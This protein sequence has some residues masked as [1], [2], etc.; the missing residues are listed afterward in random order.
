MGVAVWA[1]SRT[2]PL[3]VC[4]DARLTDA[5]ALQYPA[6]THKGQAGW[7]VGVLYQD[8]SD[9]G[10]RLATVMNE[11]GRISRL[12][13]NSHGAPGYF[14]LDGSNPQLMTQNDLFLNIKTMGNRFNSQLALIKSYLTSDAIVLFMGCNFGRGE[15]G[16][17]FLRNLSGTLFNN[18]IVVAFTTVGVSMQQ[19]RS[20]GGC[21]EPGMRDTDFEEG[22][23]SE[24]QENTR[25]AYGALFNFPWCS[26]QSPHAKV[27]K[28][29][30]ITRNPDLPFAFGWDYIVGKWT[31]EIGLWSGIFVFEKSGDSGGTVFWMDT[32]S[33]QKHGGSWSVFD[34]AVSWQFADDPP[35]FKRTFEAN[36][37]LSPLINGVAYSSGRQMGFFKMLKETPLPPRN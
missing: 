14:D 5:S 11:R 28:N 12:A 35:G 33:L 27:A 8:A 23:S 10:R 6:G 32:T 4:E 19:T 25:Y 34:G 24:S 3:K 15:I 30:D 36:L 22:A 21:S 31:V 26:E 16:S 7:D 18:L 9:L 13:I 1:N 2:A 29:G 37:P 17:N 20:G